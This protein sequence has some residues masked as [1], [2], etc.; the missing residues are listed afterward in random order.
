[1]CSICGYLSTSR[2]PA[3]LVLEMLYKTRHR[4]PDGYGLY[5]DGE[6]KK[7]NKLEDLTTSKKA[8]ICLAHARLKIIGGDDALQP[9]T[10]CNNVFSLICNGEIYNY[11]EIEE[12]LCLKH[13]FKTD[14]D[15][16]VLLHLIEELYQGDLLKAVKKAL[17]LI[18]GMYAFAV[19]DGKEIVVARDPLGQKPVYYC[20]S[21]DGVFFCSEKKGLWNLA[22]KR[23]DIKKIAPG[24]ILRISKFGTRIYLGLKIEVPQIDITDHNEAVELYSRTLI[25]AVKKRVRGLSSKKVGVVFSGGVD[26]T[27]IAKILQDLKMNVMCYCV[28]SAVSQDV[29]YAKRVCKDLSLKLR[30]IQ[31]NLET[32]EKILP[33]VMEAVEMNGPIQVE[34]AIPLYLAS[35]QAREDGILVLF[36]GQAPDEL[37][38]GYQWY[39]NLLTKEGNI[40][41]HQQL[42]KDINLLYQDTL[43]REDKVAMAHGVE[44]RAPYIDRDFIR[45]AMRIS[46]TLK[47]KSAADKW[48]HR[49]AAQKMGIPRYVAFRRKDGSQ[50]GS[51]VHVLITKLAKSKIK[52]I[53]QKP[54]I[55]DNGSNYRYLKEVYG[56]PQELAYL[57]EVWQKVAPQN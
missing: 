39:Q 51:G 27:L 5:I 49:E 14:S 56:S 3:K 32:V 52:E 40:K 30:T 38:A 26:S 34:A 25:Q 43:E 37:F 9:F 45:V 29:E 20:K 13:R 31:V 4:G 36:T 16:E 18:T 10:D 1:M 50:S 23:I 48:I 21:D 42:W 28:G 22:N 2:K 55:E 44:L 11:K 12:N 6:I 46:P 54:K 47:I 57:N 17:K 15:N 24:K 33:Q 19:T 53:I 8:R 41:L 35:E 7:S